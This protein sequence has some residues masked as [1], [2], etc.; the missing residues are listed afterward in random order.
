MKECAKCKETISLDN[1]TKDKSRKDGLHPYCKSCRKKQMQDN[2]YFKNPK[3]KITCVDCGIDISHMSQSALRCE[4]CKHIKEK[5]RKRKLYEENKD[6]LEYKIKRRIA[7]R[8]WRE[9]NFK[10]YKELQKKH[11]KKRKE[12]NE[13]N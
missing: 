8:L 11:N 4:G 13:F 3:I 2:Y 5:K 9:R 1:F 10:R 7:N 12:K 6:K